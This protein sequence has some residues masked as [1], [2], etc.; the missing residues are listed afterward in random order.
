M[1]DSYSSSNPYKRK[2]RSFEKKHNAVVDIIKRRR[3]TSPTSVSQSGSSSPPTPPS[4]ESYRRINGELPPLPQLAPQPSTAARVA[5][6]ATPVSTTP[7][8]Q[9]QQSSS[10]L[11]MYRRPGQIGFARRLSMQMGMPA[12]RLPVATT[13]QRHQ[14]YQRHI[15]P[16]PHHRDQSPSMNHSLLAGVRG[17]PMRHPHYTVAGS[18]HSAAAAAD[19]MHPLGVPPHR[20]SSLP[21]GFN[22]ALMSELIQR[23]RLVRNAAMVRPN[24]SSL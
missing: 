17:L 1:G 8:Q 11:D 10:L 7:Q 21:A 5:A 24:L 3:G 9:Q 23:Q 6:I 4:P 22:S 15:T 2:R 14:A 12:G 19:A 20:R 16:S 13:P 18:P